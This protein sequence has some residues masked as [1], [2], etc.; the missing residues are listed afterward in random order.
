MPCWWT[1]SPRRA[2][3]PTSTNSSTS[4][5][6][7][8][9][10]CRATA[11][12]P[13]EVQLANNALDGKLDNEQNSRT[14]QRRE[15]DCGEKGHHGRLLVEDTYGRATLVKCNAAPLDGVHC[16][17]DP[18][19][20]AEEIYKANLKWG[21]YPRNDGQKQMVTFKGEPDVTLHDCQGDLIETED[22]YSVQRSHDQGSQE[23]LNATKNPSVEVNA[24]AEVRYYP[25]TS[26]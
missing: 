25:G 4:S 15:L 24:H 20:P 11:C 7:H 10:T 12:S 21:T 3:I 26:W 5:S 6:R 2:A 17:G 14:L 9:R 22:N 13:P 19:C 18:W 1:T 23:C 16:H 8:Q